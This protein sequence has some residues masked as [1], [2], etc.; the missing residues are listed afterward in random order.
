[1]INIKELCRTVYPITN[2]V[3]D[4]LTRNS[5]NKKKKKVVS[6]TVEK[7]VLDELA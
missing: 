1:M 6:R 3:T 2:F 7:S 5:D 4:Y